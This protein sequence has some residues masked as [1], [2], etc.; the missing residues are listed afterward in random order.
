VVEVVAVFVVVAEAVCFSRFV[1]TSGWPDRPVNECRIARNTD[2]VV[3]CFPFALAVAASFS[4]SAGT[5]AAAEDAGWTSTC[6]V[7]GAVAAVVD[8]LICCVEVCSEVS[9]P[10]EVPAAPSWRGVV[11]SSEAGPKLS[12][13][14][15]RR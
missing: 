7:A 6:E 15:R 8:F 12:T 5:A 11:T 14:R 3:R 13:L 10:T 4:L 9:E 2:D 1:F